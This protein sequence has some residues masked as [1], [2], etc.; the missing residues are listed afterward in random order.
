MSTAVALAFFAALVETDAGGPH[1]IHGTFDR[2]RAKE[3]GG[4]AVRDGFVNDCVFTDNQCFNGD[5]VPIR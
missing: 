5:C 3:G 4:L 2:N 1:V